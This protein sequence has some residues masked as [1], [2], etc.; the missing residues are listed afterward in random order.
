MLRPV[1]FANSNSNCL[2]LFSA[3]LHPATMGF[4]QSAN[5]GR[6]RIIPQS[7]KF[8]SP[9]RA[10][11][12]ETFYA[13]VLLSHAFRTMKHKAA[14]HARLRCFLIFTRPRRL[15]VHETDSQPNS[16][17]VNNLVRL[18]HTKDFPSALRWLQAARVLFGKSQPPKLKGSPLVL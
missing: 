5:C 11:F 9:R 12:L 16:N 17:W 6:R 3:F 10:L 7:S 15:A 8:V 13:W 1:S 18:M 14:R 4:E 2:L